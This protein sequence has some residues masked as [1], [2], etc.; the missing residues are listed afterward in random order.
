[1]RRDL[2]PFERSFRPDVPPP[3][4][5]GQRRYNPLLI[6]GIPVFFV[7]AFYLML[8]VVT[9]ADQIFFPGNELHL[10][11]FKVIPGVDT[12]SN[13]ASA[14]I[15]QRIN[16]VVMG[17]DLRR[18][19]PEDTPAR[20]DSIF[21]LTLDPFSKTAGIFSIPRDTL[22]EIPDGRG[23]YIKDRINVAYETGQYT[24]KDYPGGG[25]GLVKDTI[26]H[27]FGI[28]I[29]HYVILNFNNFISLVD[30]LGGIDVDVPEYV[31]DGA[32][33]DCK[34]CPYYAVEFLPGLQHMD[35]KTALAYARLRKT[36]NDFK[37]IERQQLV[38]K[39]IA[40]RASDMGV[41]LGSN[42]INLYKKYKDSVRT[43]ISDFK[44]PGLAALGKQIGV[45]NI[46]M[47][48]MAPATY[49]CTSGCGGAAVLLWDKDKMEEIKARVFNDGQL[50][51]EHALL[52]VLNGTQTPDLASSLASF[53]AKQGIAPE[54]IQ[55]DEYAGG[56]LWEKTVI[57]DFS[58]K[59][60]TAK[61]LA[62]W[63]HL[64]PSRIL[65]A[66]DIG[67]GRVRELSPASDVIVVLGGDVTMPDGIVTGDSAADTATA[68]G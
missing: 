4:V 68:G 10:G 48:S 57:Y 53:L 5:P 46:I 15:E 49:P 41:L 3:E 59:S 43:D 33:N 30:E 47:V 27:N 61:K 62:G 22:V 31:Y 13:P 55:I 51:A 23:G 42:P 12:G 9:Q 32:Y 40:K 29:D 44:I 52:A 28:P 66:T 21:V 14:S 6:F 67:A 54:Q 56:G 16:I 60:Y 25:P 65:P 37:R 19:E 64:D 17:L 11:V 38:M 45:D 24:Y 35:G 1:M 50:Q 8:V 63:L 26:E 18:D 20:T 2:P 7:V 36:D 39:A 34:Q 58:G